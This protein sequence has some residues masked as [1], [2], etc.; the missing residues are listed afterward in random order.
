MYFFV[1]DDDLIQLLGAG[2]FTVSIS[3]SSTNP[4]PSKVKTKTLLLLE[5]SDSYIKPKEA[6]GI[7]KGLM[8][9]I[10]VCSSHCR[11]F[12]Q[13]YPNRVQSNYLPSTEQFTR[14]HA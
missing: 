2:F 7:Y 11:I 9:S 1:V 4:N 6:L 8:D 10:F 5:Y 3:L 13:Y 12:E 14:F